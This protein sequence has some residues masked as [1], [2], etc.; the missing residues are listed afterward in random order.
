MFGLFGSSK[1]E[2]AANLLETG[3]RAVGTVTNVRDTGVTIND[4][5]VRV[6]LRFKIEP[7]DGA[8]AFDGE[9]TTTVS[10]V[11]IPQVGQ[12]FPVWFNP[13]DPTEFAYATTD[14]G[15]EARQNIVAMFGDAFGPDGSGVGQAAAAA[16]VAAAPADPI[17]QIAKLQSL[18]EAGALTDAEFEAQKQRIL[19]GT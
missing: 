18:R 12:R 11:S 8:P 5:N 13:A 17:E 2:K 7:L 14:G 9:K 1:K 10:R 19:S 16:P 15:A 6:G 3:T 4:L